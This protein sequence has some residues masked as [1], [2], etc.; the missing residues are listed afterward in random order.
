MQARI[1][2]DGRLTIPRLH[3]V[4]CPFDRAL[5]APFRCLVALSLLR[6]LQSLRDRLLLLLLRVGQRAACTRFARQQHPRRGGRRRGFAWGHRAARRA[7]AGRC[8]RAAPWRGG[9]SR[10]HRRPWRRERRRRAGGKTAG[11]QLCRWRRRSGGAAR[12]RGG[13]AST[14]PPPR[15]WR[16][17]AA[18]QRG[19][20]RRARR[21]RTSGRA[22]PAAAWCP[23]RRR[24]CACPG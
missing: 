20:A 5:V 9:G 24:R 1:S 15:R 13:R 18:R 17:P 8:G 3:A 7:V 4:R 23:R 12:R 14:R 6:P 2:E 21:R 19:T 11:P 22:V 16:G 10:A